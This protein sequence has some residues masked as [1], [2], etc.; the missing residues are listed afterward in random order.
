MKKIL[1]FLMA[2]LLVAPFLASCSSNN[3][4]NTGDTNALSNEDSNASVDTALTEANSG[5]G[6]ENTP[7]TLPDN[8]DFDGKTLRIVGRE[9]DY[10]PEMYCDEW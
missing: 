4:G 5:D 1:V 8:L 10:F 6:R 2:V 3:E 7:D 9:W